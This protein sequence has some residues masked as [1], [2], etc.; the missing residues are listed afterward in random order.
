MRV[1]S[2]RI[3]LFIIRKKPHQHKYNPLTYFCQGVFIILLSVYE[4][5]VIF[6]LKI[7]RFTEKC[8][9][10]TA[11]LF[12]GSLWLRPLAF[13]RNR[14]KNVSLRDCSKILPERLEYALSRRQNAASAPYGLPPMLAL[15]KALTLCDYGNSS[16]SNSGLVKNSSN[17]IATSGSSSS[18]SR[19]RRDSRT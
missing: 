12:S 6:S 16:S 11:T 5:K 15:Y 1:A 13:L 10:R 8:A 18:S 7:V 3:I 2:P 17:V 4:L 14:T 19:W 9:A